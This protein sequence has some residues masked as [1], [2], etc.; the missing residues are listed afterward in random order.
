MFLGN[1]F[2]H[3]NQGMS[4]TNLHWLDRTGFKGI[5]MTHVKILRNIFLPQQICYNFSK[6][7]K[8]HTTFFPPTFTVVLQVQMCKLL[9]LPLL[10][11]KISWDESRF[12]NWRLFS[13]D[14]KY[15]LV[16]QLTDWQNL[17]T[18]PDVID[19]LGMILLIQLNVYHFNHPMFIWIVAD[20]LS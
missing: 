8:W 6:L 4:S 15:M 16:P 1:K 2:T 20:F 17:P 10:T 19:L 12:I 11:C 18:E 13:D 7:N 5:D 9:K 3:C 14:S